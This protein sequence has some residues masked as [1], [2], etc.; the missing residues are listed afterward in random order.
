MHT[1]YTHALYY[2]RLAN[3]AYDET[4]LRD[5]E[6][7]ITVS[8][9]DEDQAIADRQERLLNVDL[10][11]A[12]EQDHPGINYEGMEGEMRRLLSELFRGAA[13]S[14]G[15]WPQS[16]AYYSVDVIFDNAAQCA[17]NSSGDKSSAP[18]SNDDSQVKGEESGYSFTPVP[19]LVEVNF[20]GDWHGVEA[21]VHQPGD[22]HEWATDLLTV[23]ATTQDV[24]GNE[25]LIPL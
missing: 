12:L 17:K 11:A 14:I 3:K 1:A 15:Q 2:A 9:Y 18:N 7:S 23:L 19:K 22:Y 13:G 5:P 16:S 6:V 8:A 24:S 10:R 21:A 25:R 20:M 4:R